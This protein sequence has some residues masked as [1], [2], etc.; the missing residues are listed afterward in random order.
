MWQ[1][2]E[3]P[4]SDELYHYGVKGMKWGIRRYQYKKGGLTPEGN[5]RYSDSEVR[6]DISKTFYK[7]AKA[8]D[9]LTVKAS[10]ASLRRDKAVG[11]AS[12]A[13]S[14]YSK[15]SYKFNKKKQAYQDSEDD[16][17]DMRL[18]G[19]DRVLRL[20][21]RDAKLQSKATKA[22]TKVY[23]TKKKSDK[24]IK[25]MEGAFKDIS[26]NEIDPEVLSKGR[27]YAY[28]LFDEDKLKR[29]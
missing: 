3:T 20:E 4:Y 8:A 13:L 14:K 1:Y 29:R 7:S 28:M 22:N 5:R 11:K 12:K 26:I 19:E 23:K 21:K 18:P 24:F 9:R 27:K 10:K 2:N 6:N 15:A 25:A 16:Y 17:T